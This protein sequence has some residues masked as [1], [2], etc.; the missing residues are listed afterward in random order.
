ML[1]ASDD[2][3]ARLWSADGASEPVI[4]GRHEGPVTAAAFSPDGTRIVTA[5]E[6]GTARVWSGDGSGELL[7]L[8]GHQGSV[9]TASFSADGRE[10]S[11][12]S[13]PRSSARTAGGSSRPR[14]PSTW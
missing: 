14:S 5:S 7:V 1:T 6:D 2:G 13:K 4:L 10:R 9:A 8:R 3:T 12:W 11:P